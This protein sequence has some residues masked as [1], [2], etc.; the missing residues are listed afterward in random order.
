MP[1]LGGVAIYISLMITLA[2]LV[3]ST[4]RFPKNARVGEGGLIGIALGG[5]IIF[6]L[7]LLDDLE[8]LP[9]KLKLL[10]QILAA[11]CCLFIGSKN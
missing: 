11:L 3:A 8:S 5:T 2:I 6:L 7:G 4:G 1:R 10:V 9:A